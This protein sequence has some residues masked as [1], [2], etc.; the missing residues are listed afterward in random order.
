[1]QMNSFRP[2]LETLVLLARLAAG[3]VTGSLS[4]VALAMYSG[5]DVF[6]GLTGLLQHAQPSTPPGDAPRFG[7]S[8]YPAVFK[9]A[10]GIALIAVAV[11]VFRTAGRKM[12]IAPPVGNYYPAIAVLAASILV[13]VFF[14]ARQS[15]AGA[16][17]RTFNFGLIVSLAVLAV[18]VT[19]QLKRFVSTDPV[20]AIIVLIFSL[21]RALSLLLE[22]AKELMDNRLPRREEEWIESFI[23]EWGGKRFELRDLSARKIGNKRYLDFH[24]KFMKN[25]DAE[26]AFALANDLER[27]LMAK[28]PG[29]M[30]IIH[31]ESGPTP[32]PATPQ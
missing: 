28:I 25:I 10:G 1:M 20:I 31:V 18:L 2:W 8:K 3:I 24:L 30:V 4:L 32:G 12:E 23:R 19:V 13:L 15:T 16:R 21:V 6:R 29:A 7:F 14:S 26:A 17:Q 11:S 9:A 22:S 5:A 27:V